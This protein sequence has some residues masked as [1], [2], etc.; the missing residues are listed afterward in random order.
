MRNYISPLTEFRGYDLIHSLFALPHAAIAARAAARWNTPFVMGAQGTYGITPFLNA[1]SR[2]MFS[3]ILD[4][5]ARLIVPSEFTASAILSFYD[6]NGLDERV[7]IIHNGVDYAL[8]SAHR[9][10]PADDADGF[11]FIGI[12]GLKPRKGFHVTIAAMRQV[13]DRNPKTVYSIAGSGSGPYADGLRQMTA[14]LGLN[15]NVRFLDHVD[16]SE[17]PGVLRENAAYAH[18]P[19]CSNWNF[20]GFGIVYLEAN[21][22]G[23]PAI[24]ARSGGVPDAIQDGETGLLCAERSIDDTARKMIYL[25]ENRELYRAMQSSAHKWAKDHDWSRIVDSYIGEYEAVLEGR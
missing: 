1:V 11:S 20:E 24:G 12:G 7:R 21:A 10:A 15:D 13:A 23:L 17:L 22:A 14:E 19:I 8:F 2:R 4:R 5:A 18:T 16:N 6:A 3:R 25:M 9:R